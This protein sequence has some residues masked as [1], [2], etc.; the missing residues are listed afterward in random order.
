MWRHRNAQKED[1]HVKMKVEIGV[2]LQEV[3][4]HLWLPEARNSK[5]RSS[6]SSLKNSVALSTP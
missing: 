1:S 5:E 3:K 2:I 4:E 6:L